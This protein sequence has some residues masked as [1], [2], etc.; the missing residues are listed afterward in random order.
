MPRPPDQPAPSGPFADYLARQ[1]RDWFSDDPVVQ[2]LVAHASRVAQAKV[3]GVGRMAATSASTA[4]RVADQ[5]PPQARARDDHGRP[6]P[7]GLTVCADTRRVLAAALTAGAALEEDPAVRRAMV[8]LLAQGG[9]GGWVAPLITTAAAVQA[10][11]AHAPGPALDH[12]RTQAP[13]GPVHAAIDFGCPG[14]PTARFDATNGWARYRLLETPAGW[15][16]W[17][18]LHDGQ[19]NG[20][21]VDGVRP[22]LGLRATGRAELVLDSPVVQDLP[23][24]RAILRAEV[25]LGIEAALAGFLRGA[26]RCVDA[27]KPGHPEV[28]ELLAASRLWLETGMG[29]A[30][31]PLLI[32][33]GRALGPDGLDQTRTPL[34]RL[35]RDALAL[36][37]LL[38]PAP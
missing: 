31:A 32:D 13:G 24:L 1:S 27:W 7:V 2:T 5:T 28:A 8:Y 23:D 30:V 37:L 3:R 12:L 34:P 16:L 36:P 17:S 14:L 26:A 19:P 6:H 33:A 11:T 9:D 38:S 10:L 35:L 18:R 29:P 4:A 22:T 21:R 20:F 25:A 15:R